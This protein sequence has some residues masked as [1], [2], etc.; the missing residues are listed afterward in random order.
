[1]GTCW[2]LDAATVWKLL[3]KR[4]I[5]RSWCSAAFIWRKP[6]PCALCSLQ[7]IEEEVWGF[8]WYSKCTNFISTSAYYKTYYK[9]VMAAGACCPEVSL[10]PGPCWNGCSTFITVS[11]YTSEESYYYWLIGRA[12]YKFISITAPQ[13]MLTCPRFF[14]KEQVLLFTFEKASFA[15]CM[16]K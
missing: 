7:P 5:H 1:M 6:H 10:H 9:T 12:M 2:K 15:T 14:C 4:I 3:L 8:F 16:D 13:Q 11:L